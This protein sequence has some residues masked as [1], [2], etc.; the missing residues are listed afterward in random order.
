[1][2]SANRSQQSKFPQ[3][4]LYHLIFNELQ[5]QLGNVGKPLSSMYLDELLKHVIS[6]EKGQYFMQNPA[7]SS[8]SSS[9]SP[10]SLFLGNFNLNGVLDKKTV[11][12]V[13]EEILHHQHLSGADN[14][15]IQHLSTLGETT[16]EEFLVR[17]GV[18]SLGNQNGSTAN[19]QPFMTMDPMAVVPQ[20]PADWFQ[21]PVE[22]AQQ[23]QPGV[24]D[25]SFHV[26]ESV[27]EGPAIEIGYS[28]NQMAMSTAVPAVTTSSPNSPVA[29]E[30]KRWFSDEMMKT[31]ERRQKRM[32][33]NRESAARSRARKQA[34]TNHLEHEVHQLKKENDLL[35]RLKELQMRWSLNPT[36]GPKYQLRR[37]SSCLF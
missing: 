30:R 31:I 11:E 15:P 16:L 13:W 33:K 2:A 14:G 35:I 6:A 32:I 34:Y 20:Q 5:T 28:K 26:S 23:Q 19:A 8:S 22:A 7:A 36:P 37:T 3:G 4:Y 10:A 17:A 12:E 29:V 21:L 27:F 25:S 24:L 1:M 9:S 18:I